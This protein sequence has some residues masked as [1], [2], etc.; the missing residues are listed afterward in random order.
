VTQN[1]P[2]VNHSPSI[3]DRGDQPA[4]VVTYIKNYVIADDVRVFPGVPNVSEVLPIRALGDFV[5]RVQGST[6]FAMLFGC[7]SNRLSAD[8]PHEK[9]SHFEKFVSM[10]GGGT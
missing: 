3:F 5:P 10:G 1:P 9:S 8:D 2:N 4:S 6:P 7:L